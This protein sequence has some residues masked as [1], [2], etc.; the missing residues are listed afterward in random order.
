MGDVGCFPEDAILEK[1]RGCDLLLIPV[2]GYYTVDAREA[3]SIVEAVS[4]RAVVPMHYRSDDQG[5]GYKVIAPVEEFL[6]LLPP[7]PVTQLIGPSF[8]LTETLP[9][10]TA[11]P[12][13]EM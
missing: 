5:F 7:E 12:H 3:M 13:L 1:L 6:S 9:V 4:P 10:G 2:G 8:S 11:V